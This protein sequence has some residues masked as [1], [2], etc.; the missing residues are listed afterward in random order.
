MN[1]RQIKKDFKPDKFLL[2]T[3]K[4]R[5]LHRWLFSRMATLKEKRNGIASTQRA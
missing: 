5:D 1:K 4:D 3:K 2:D